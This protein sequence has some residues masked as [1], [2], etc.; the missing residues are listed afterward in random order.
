[1]TLLADL[2]LHEQGMEAVISIDEGNGNDGVPIEDKPHFN[3]CVC[4]QDKWRCFFSLFIF[5]DISMMNTM[6][7]ELAII[8][9]MKQELIL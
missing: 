5:V 1:M 3:C 9:S 6:D 4:V 8:W 7:Y 2:S